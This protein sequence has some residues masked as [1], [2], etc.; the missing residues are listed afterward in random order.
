MV[1]IYLKKVLQKCFRG[2]GIKFKDNKSRNG[3][4]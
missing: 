1:K 2:L 4:P 3:F